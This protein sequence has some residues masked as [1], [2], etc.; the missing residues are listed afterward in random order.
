VGRI[1]H[2]IL[3][4]VK[5]LSTSPPLSEILHVQ[6][7][8]DQVLHALSVALVALHA[9][10]QLPHTVA[11][12]IKLSM[13]VNPSHKK[14][15]VKDVEKTYVLE[16]LVEKGVLLRSSDGTYSLAPEKTEEQ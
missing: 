15:T 5:M 8:G 7:T 2:N 6:L 11:G 10:A 13:Q 16:H 4:V 12:A 1:L 3:S 9:V 14:L